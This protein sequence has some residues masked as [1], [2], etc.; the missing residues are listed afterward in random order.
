ML[1]HYNYCTCIWQMVQQQQLFHNS[2][3][4]IQSIVTTDTN[5]FRLHFYTV[6]SMECFVTYLENTAYLLTM[7][8]FTHNFAAVKA[9][10]MLLQNIL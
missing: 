7:T 6:F 10:L 1:Q 4:C 8:V 2:Q 3:Q 5:I 9:S